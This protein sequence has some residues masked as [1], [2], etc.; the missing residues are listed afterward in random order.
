MQGRDAATLEGK[1][2][3]E[4]WSA[5]QNASKENEE[6]ARDVFRRMLRRARKNRYV[7]IVG[8]D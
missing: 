2:L 8:D 5:L 7:K 1:M 6:D 4:Y 3:N